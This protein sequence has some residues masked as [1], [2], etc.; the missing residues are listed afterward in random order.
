MRAIA[1]IPI[2]AKSERIPG[3]NFAVVNGRPLYQHVIQNACISGA[4]DAICV[5]TDS[6]EIARWVEEQPKVVNL[7]AIP[8]APAIRG[9]MVNGNEL[10][11]HDRKQ[12]VGSGHAA[13]VWVQLFATSPF[14]KPE[15]MQRA[16]N[17][18]RDNPYFD[19]VFAAKDVTHAFLWRDGEPLYDV[20]RFP[21]SQDWPHKVI[22]ETTGL[23]AVRDSTLRV[24]GRRVGF[25]PFPL[26]VDPQ[27]ALDIDWP[28][29]LKEV[30]NHG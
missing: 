17:I 1:T 30:R 21:R 12:L 4:F 22:A 28:E 5:D 18:L 10:L 27:E 26:I 3:K 20:Q 13:E 7:F 23:Y 11:C 6:Q 14:L 19:S 24:Q 8:R 2:K 25:R 29:D 16:V 15:T 9:Q